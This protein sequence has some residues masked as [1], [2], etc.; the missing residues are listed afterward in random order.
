M[1]VGWKGSKGGPMALARKQG[2]IR[3]TDGSLGPTC[4][5]NLMCSW[6]RKGSQANL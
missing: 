1:E 4:R 2:K 5:G 3:Q 6:R